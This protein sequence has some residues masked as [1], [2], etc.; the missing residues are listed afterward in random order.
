M[1]FSVYL[2]K[3][4]AFENISKEEAEHK[5]MILQQ[6]IRAGVPSSYTEEQ[7]K[8]IEIKPKND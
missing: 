3:K 5:Q 7:V 4:P 2:D 8:V 6:M 1:A